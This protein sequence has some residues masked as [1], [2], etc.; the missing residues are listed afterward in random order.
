MDYNSRHAES[1]RRG[2]HAP[3]NQGKDYQ[4]AGRGGAGRV[5][6][7]RFDGRSGAAAVAAAAARRRRRR[8]RRWCSSSLSST[9]ARSSSFLC[10]SYPCLTGGGRPGALRPEGPGRGWPVWGPGQGRGN[11]GGGQRRARVPWVL[12]R[13]EAS[14]RLEDFGGPTPPSPG[15]PSQPYSR[16]AR[17]GLPTA[18]AS[19]TPDPLCHAPALA[20]GFSFV[21]LGGEGRGLLF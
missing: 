8:W 4:E 9:V 17:P 15:G 11:E 1:C 13:L 7:N 2:L 14:S 5:T 12:A 3:T 6:L 20:L 18:S 16:S 19:A 21:A 10:T